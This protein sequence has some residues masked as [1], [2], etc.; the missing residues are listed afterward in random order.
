MAGLVPPVPAP[1]CVV[2]PGIAFVPQAPSLAELSREVAEQRG[3]HFPPQ[4]LNAGLPGLWEEAC[5]PRRSR[6]LDAECNPILT[7][8][9][10]FL[11]LKDVYIF[12]LYIQVF[13]ES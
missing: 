2:F 5:R 13:P 3:H 12:L 4:P 8:E 1:F 10:R 11:F 6:H 7:A 9:C